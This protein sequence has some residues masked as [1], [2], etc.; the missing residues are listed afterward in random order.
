MNPVRV[1]FAPS[2]TGALH[3]GGLRTALYNY[4]FARGNGGVFVLRIEDT[5]Q[6]RY[7]EGAEEYIAES[8]EWCG[9]SPDEGP[10][11]GGNYGPYRQS[12]R[13][14]IYAEY[15][16]K[17]LDNG[18]AYYAFDT[19]EELND[20]REAEKAAGN[21]NFRYDAATRMGM[22]NSLSLSAEE[23]AKLLESNA[24][25][26]VRLKV[27]PGHTVVINDIVRGRVEFASAEVDDKVLMKADGLPTYHLANVV[28]DHLMEISHVIRGEEWLP[29]TA[30]HVLLYRAFGW[31]DTM[32]QFAHLPLL[33]K[34]TGKGKL[35]KRDGQKL[36]IPVF[37]INWEKGAPEDFLQG[38]RE[39]GLLPAATI[40][41]L[42]FL[43]WNPGTEQELFQLEELVEAFSLERINKSGAR[44]DFDKARWFNQQYLITTPVAEVAPLV[45]AQFA[46]AGHELS[47]E[48]AA[49]ITEM[50]RERVHLI[51]EFFTK[52]RFF[53]EPVSEYEEKPIRKK[54]KPEQRPVFD[55]LITDL[56]GLDDWSAPAIKATTVAFMER[57]E[58]GFGA[59]LPILRVA[60]SGTVQGPDAFEML[61]V[62]GRENTVSRLRTG[63]DAFDQI[64]AG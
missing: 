23:T 51:P 29:S 9:I 45:R 38:F 27:D 35:S 55:Q 48:L 13:R 46:A 19:E 25:R 44:F 49:T 24:P 60:V 64:K 1:R 52:G 50:L 21:H 63:Y 10:Q 31:E 4:L 7:V 11:K 32:P 59:V 37:P 39:T 3:I 30:L 16:Q 17:L 28:D 53:V 36:G 14:E 62:V 18:S 43:G 34:P 2:P 5:D 41:F 6:K 15:T 40:N 58:L 12:E 54:W 22:R 20:R 47:D 26:V 8:L 42:A 33:L 56:A 61:A 57:N